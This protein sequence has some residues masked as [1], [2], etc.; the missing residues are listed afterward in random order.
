MSVYVYLPLRRGEIRLFRLLPGKVTEPLAGN[1]A[2]FSIDSGVP[3]YSALSY[4]W[5][6]ENPASD[7]LLLPTASKRVTSNL[8]CALRYLRRP[9]SELLL[10]VDALCINQDDDVEKAQQVARMRDVYSIASEVVAFLGGER[11]GR[12][13][14][15]TLAARGAED[16]AIAETCPSAGLTDFIDCLSPTGKESPWRGL[17]TMLRRPWFSRIWVVQEALV[18]RKVS[19]RY[20]TAS[21]SALQL[22]DLVSEIAHK[23]NPLFFGSPK[24]QEARNYMLGSIGL[25]RKIASRDL[26]G[27]HTKQK[28]D[29]LDLLWHYRGLKATKAR[30]HLFALLGL[31]NVPYNKLLSPDYVSSLESIVIRYAHYFVQFG[32]DPLRLLYSANGV[33]IDNRFASWIPN[34]MLNEEEPGRSGHISSRFVEPGKIFYATAVSAS[35]SMRI[36]KKG[37]V[38]IVSGSIFGHIT[39]V[40]EDHWSNVDH[41][42]DLNQCRQQYIQESDDFVHRVSIYPTGEELKDV[43][44]RLL[45]GNRAWNPGF[46]YINLEDDYVEQY[47]VFRRTFE[48]PRKTEQRL[49]D[50]FDAAAEKGNTLGYISSLLIVSNLRF[51]R[52]KNG[53]LGLAPLGT[54]V[55]DVVCIVNGSCVPFILRPSQDIKGAFQLV[56]KCYIHGIM[57]GEALQ[58]KDLVQREISLV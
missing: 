39:M 41:E 45:V 23:A 32:R 1:L 33:S 2:H 7:I 14:D 31:A 35:P 49:V 47:H 57:E 34:W 12:S 18:A 48:C 28:A 46:G 9:D 19:F 13:A 42:N 4:V 38:L 50:P 52:T 44:I 10:W 5:G 29:L 16:Q 30:D 53:Y 36:G 37:I 58:M 11:N 43:Q 8:A 20:G 21:I 24:E 25:I 15:T 55:G 17:F 6:N 56:G 27:A 51:C 40:G 22:A 3:S 26:V 54:Q